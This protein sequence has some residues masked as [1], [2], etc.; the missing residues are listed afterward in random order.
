VPPGEPY[1]ADAEQPAELSAEPP[2][3]PLPTGI[4]ARTPLGPDGEPIS[5]DWPGQPVKFPDDV[6]LHALMLSATRLLGA[7]GQHTVQAA[8]LKISLAG[9][10][11]LRVLMGSDGL[12]STELADRAWSSPGTVT[13]VV[14]T[15][16]KGDF[17]ERRPDETDRRVV[18]LYITGQGRALISYYVPQAAARWRKAFDFVDEADEAVIRQFFLQMIDHLSQLTREEPGA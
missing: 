7:Y 11:V 1:R 9:L 8:G 18:R 10:G 15:L 6:P 4:G 14:N 17:V 16:V 12:K 13:S 3:G 2:P 5:W